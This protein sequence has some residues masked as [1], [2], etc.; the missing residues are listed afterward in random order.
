MPNWCETEYYGIPNQEELEWDEE[1]NQMPHFS[2][3]KTI[4][5]Y[6]NEE[7]IHFDYDK[8]IK[9]IPTYDEFCDFYY[10]IFQE[11]PSGGEL[12]WDVKRI[13]QPHWYEK[14]EVEEAEDDIKHLLP[15]DLCDGCKCVHSFYYGM[16]DYHDELVSW[17][18][19]MQGKRD[20]EE[21]CKEINPTSEEEMDYPLGEELMFD[22]LRAG[23]QGIFAQAEKEGFKIVNCEHYERNYE[24][25][26][27]AGWQDELLKEF[28]EEQELI[29]DMPTEE[30]LEEDTIRMLGWDHDD[31]CKYINKK[32]SMKT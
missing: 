7:W 21:V 31:W 27:E 29:D 11:I 19:Y 17:D 9:Q 20:W 3:W 4:G 23:H 1:R 8:I 30:E 14:N 2:G 24:A 12:E 16:F 32:K 22:E 25:L 10:N 26:Y 18:T 5:E 6:S 13:Q 15:R 28:L